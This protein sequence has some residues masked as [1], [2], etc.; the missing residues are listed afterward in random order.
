L[1]TWGMGVRQVFVLFLS[2]EMWKNVLYSFDAYF[3]SAHSLIVLMEIRR[4]RNKIPVKF[5]KEINRN[6]VKLPKMN[7]LQ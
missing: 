7:I 3:H 1:S 6:I 5:Q 2:K 4:H